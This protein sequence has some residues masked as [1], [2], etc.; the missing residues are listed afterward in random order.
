MFKKLQ[1]V[2]LST[3]IIFM[4]YTKTASAGFVDCSGANCG[5]NNLVDTAV[6]ISSWLL[7]VAGSLALLMFIYGGIMFLISSG[8]SERV[9][10]GK[11]ILTNSI[12]GLAIILLSFLIIGFVFKALGVNVEGTAWAKVGWFK[13]GG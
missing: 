1:K 4:F 3:L 11:T 8:S 2:V 12:I 5:L 10:K 9:S 13:G 6:E 7:G